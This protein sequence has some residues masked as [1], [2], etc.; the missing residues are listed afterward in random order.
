MILREDGRTV[1]IIT[2]KPSLLGVA[3]KILMM[4]DG[5]VGMFGPRDDVFA[6]IK[7]MMPV[8][9]S[10]RSPAVANGKNPVRERQNA[11]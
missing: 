5:S 1:V 9:I 2:H 10:P 11:T 3:D 8:P 6:K 7:N 4:Q